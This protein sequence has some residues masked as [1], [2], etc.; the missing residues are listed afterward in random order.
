MN[1]ETELH[2]KSPKS[3]GYWETYYRANPHPFNPSPFALAMAKYLEQPGDLIE[4]GCGNGRDAVFLN[5]Q[6]DGRVIAIDQCL[7]EMERLNTAHGNT[8]LVFVGADFSTYEPATPPRYIYSRWTMHAIDEEAEKRTL[9]MVARNLLPGGRFFVEARGIGDN[10]YGKGEQVGEHAFF[11]DHYRR[12]MDRQRFMARLEARGLEIIHSEASHGLAVYKD[13]D[14][15]IVR[16]IATR[17]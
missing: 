14:P 2:E 1:P 17:P 5:R 11:T 6:L 12:F 10:L 16:L 9:D 4:L 3:V 15:L 7:E 13:D 8:G